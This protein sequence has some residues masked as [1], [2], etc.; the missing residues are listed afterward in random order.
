MKI[1]ETVI[2]Y[3]DYNYVEGDLELKFSGSRLNQ[4]INGDEFSVE[5]ILS[6]KLH[7]NKKYI[8]PDL[9]SGI[10]KD[11]VFALQLP[12]NISTYVNDGDKELA[13]NANFDK[14]I[15]DDAFVTENGELK[16]NRFNTI[17]D[18]GKIY[19]T[20]NVK[21]YGLKKNN[22]EEIEKISFYE[23]F[24]SVLGEGK[25]EIEPKK[26][27]YA[28]G[29]KVNIRAIPNTNATFIEW[30]DDFRS[31]D[32]EEL[33][34]T[35]E[36][37][38]HFTALFTKYQNVPSPKTGSFWSDVKDAYNSNK[39][40]SSLFG[41]VDSQYQEGSGY[42]SKNEQEEKVGCMGS[43]LE[44]IALLFQVI[45][46]L[47]YLGIGLCLLFVVISAFGWDSLWF[48]GILF[49]LWLV[50]KLFEFL[51][52]FN[53]LVYL[54]N[55]LFIGIIGFTLFNLF[56]VIDFN[57]VV[58]QEK[59]IKIPETTER[60]KENNS[61]D[62]I[63]FIEWI[64]SKR[65]NYST[66]LKV[67]SDFVSYEN[68]IKRSFPLLQ[69]EQD[70]NFLLKRLYQESRE[71]LY[72]VYKSLDSIK[73]RNNI[74]K[75]DFP[76][77]IVSMVQHI[78]YVAILNESCNPFDYQDESLRKLLQHNPCQGYVKY[79]L[80]SPSEFL[81]D[82]K[83]DCDSRTLFLFTILKHYGYNVAI[84][85]S[86]HYKHSLLGI[87]LPI[88]I[89]NTTSINHNGKDYYLWETTS[90]GFKIGEIS[91]DLQNTNYWNLNI[92]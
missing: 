38:L 1:I 10:N 2:V 30:Q 81:K 42:K 90:K 43:L 67:N 45:G 41:D 31:F 16:I 79:G 33:E 8:A 24:P 3:E 21:V 53:I 59:P 86:D 29:E 37:D 71:S 27:Y 64:D 54:L 52:R 26:E 68:N 58:T 57:T 23:L 70:Y 9:P 12:Y 60:V 88:V 44:G 73:S 40:L 25:I 4:F 11:R 63:H 49:G 61:I 80:K 74:S 77:V 82:L 13:F 65:N 51:G 7:V 89:E 46:Y 50:P 55:L 28:I 91:Q 75:N 83:A 85:G 84:F 32:S 47:F 76:D 6:T 39:R 19:S 5:S 36:K 17:K 66:N 72:F 69:S 56:S 15:C 18:E 20:I 35:I 78:P 48:F 34:I 87:Q 92:K 22:R 14:I 62:Y